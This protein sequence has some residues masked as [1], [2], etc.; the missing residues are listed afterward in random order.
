MSMLARQDR[1]DL[2]S[3]LGRMDRAFED[4]MRALPMRRPFAVEW[5]WP[6]EEFIRIDEYRDGDTE[7]IR[8]E[9]PGIDPEK[10]VELTVTD[11]LLRIKAERRIEERMQDKGYT[12]HELRYGTFSRVLPLPEGVSETAISASYR[13]GILEV[14]VPLPDRPVPLAP[15]R[16]AIRKG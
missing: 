10:D 1:G 4:W 3:W 2:A 13:H 6:G 9:L 11:G 14:R 12:R 7:V 5:E 16:I 15:T 8:A